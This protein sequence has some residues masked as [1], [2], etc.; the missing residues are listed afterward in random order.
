[1]GDNASNNDSMIRHLGETLN[2]FPGSA[3]QTWC[4]AHTVNLITKSILK[5]F[6]TQKTKNIQAFNDMADTLARSD[7]AEDVEQAIGD[8]EEKEDKDKDIG[9]EPDPDMDNEA[10][11]GLE[12]IRTM[13]LKVC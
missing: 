6:D 10:N 13:L 5:P 2:E 12:P 4:F 8:N 1:M 11:M 3:N 9:D 7:K